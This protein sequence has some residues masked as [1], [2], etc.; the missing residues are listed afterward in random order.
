M[1]RAIRT[2]LGDFLAILGLLVI[3]VG[4]AGY[5]LSHERLRFPF[6][7]SQPYTINAAFS[8][9]QAFAPGQGQTVVVSGVRVGQVGQVTLKNG[10][11]IVTLELDQK[12]NNV[13]HQNATALARPRT[14]LQ[15]MF[16]ELNPDPAGKPSPV[17]KAGYTI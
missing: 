15:D 4:V 8:T 17:A 10:V 13:V 5:I 1:K 3:S 6:I 14:G 16:V 11:A 2:H 12:Y 7:D 9:G